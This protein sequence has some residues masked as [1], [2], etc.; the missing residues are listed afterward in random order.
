MNSWLSTHLFS[1]SNLKKK[2]QKNSILIWF[3]FQFYYNQADPNPSVSNVNPRPLDGS[4]SSP[5]PL[6]PLYYHFLGSN[7][8]LL[9]CTRLVKVILKVNWLELAQD[10]NAVSKKL[11]GKRFSVWCVEEWRENVTVQNLFVEVRVHKFQRSQ[12]IHISLIFLDDCAFHW[13]DKNSDILT[14]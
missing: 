1:G 2:K 14:W 10:S 5:Q 6:D 8:K 7:D 4:L 13:V 9:Q 12:S 3:I 11:R